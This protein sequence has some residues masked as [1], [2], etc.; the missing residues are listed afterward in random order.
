M[1]LYGRILTAVLNQDI[2]NFLLVN[3]NM[4]PNATNLSTLIKERMRKYYRGGEEK[5]S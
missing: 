3:Q 5:N 1:L 2:S 4:N